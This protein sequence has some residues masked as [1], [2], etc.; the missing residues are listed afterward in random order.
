MKPSVA[1]ELDKPRNLRI[2]TNAM[3]KLEEMM[4]KPLSEIGTRFG[5]K[6]IRM[7]MFCGLLHEDKD[8]TLDSVGDLIDLV[9]LEYAGNKVKEVLELAVYGKQNKGE[10]ESG[11][12]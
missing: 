9:G 7:I 4:G 1:I 12:N 6:D 8:L 10:N 11:K 3:V 5:V 2:N